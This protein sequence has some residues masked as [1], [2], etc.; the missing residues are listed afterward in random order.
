M[1][2]STG[3]STS[4]QPTGRVSATWIQEIVLTRAVNPAVESATLLSGA[5]LSLIRLH[6]YNY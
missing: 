4:G 1:S 6:Y 5:E 2:R 3:K